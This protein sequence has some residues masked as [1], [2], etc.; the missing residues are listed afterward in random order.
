MQ[1]TLCTCVL[2]VPAGKVSSLLQRLWYTYVV[3]QADRSIRRCA[4]SDDMISNWQIL[5]EKTHTSRPSLEIQAENRNDLSNDSRQ[6]KGA[7]S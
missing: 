2:H 1:F 7:L 4:S 6:Q 5:V 3:I